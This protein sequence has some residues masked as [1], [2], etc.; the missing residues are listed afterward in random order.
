MSIGNRSFLQTGPVWPIISDKGVVLHQ[1]FFLSQHWD[2]QFFIRYK[3]LGISFFRFISIQEFD[4]RID[5]FVMANTA[6]HNMQR[7]KKNLKVDSLPQRT[8]DQYD[9]TGKCFCALGLAPRTFKMDDF[10]A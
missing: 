2:D 3:N 9:F 4:R 5:I 8:V 7:G 6:L 10:V 1:T